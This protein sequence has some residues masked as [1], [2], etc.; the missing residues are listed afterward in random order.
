MLNLT[1]PLAFHSL[2]WSDL[3]IIWCLYWLTIKEVLAEFWFDSSIVFFNIILMYLVIPK[4][5]MQFIQLGKQFWCMS[6]YLAQQI[7]PMQ[8]Q[9]LQLPSTYDVAPTTFGAS[10]YSFTSVIKVFEALLCFLFLS[11]NC[12]I[13]NSTITETRNSVTK[14]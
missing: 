13:L 9:Q 4:V 10:F 11:L 1:C 3:I 7:L 6:K 2:A 5:R 12:L 14:V 8:P